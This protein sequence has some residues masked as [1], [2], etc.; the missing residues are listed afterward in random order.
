M[1]F[2]RPPR[3]IPWRY[4]AGEITI[5]VMGILIALAVNDAYED[6][7]DRRRESLYLQSLATDLRSDIRELTSAV[8]RARLREHYGR[9]LLASLRHDSLSPTGFV[10]AV[11]VAPSQR[12][13]VFTAYTFDDL[14][15]TGNLRVL[16]NRALVRSLSEYQSRVQRQLQFSELYRQNTWYRFGRWRDHLLDPDLRFRLYFSEDEGIVTRTFAEQV[17]QRLRALPDVEADLQA[18]VYTNLE[19][20]DGWMGL[21]AAAEKLLAEVEQELGRGT[22]PGT[23]PRAV[24]N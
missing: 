15:S 23:A 13:P 14:K 24:R 3:T 8:E 1:R 7:Q 12:M 22:R 4:A 21:R 20:A 10:R 17:R 11:E 19:Q 9:T 16:R 18:V 2:L 5:V 6:R